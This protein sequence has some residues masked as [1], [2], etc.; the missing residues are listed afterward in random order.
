MIKN[1]ECIVPGLFSRIF[2]AR[3]VTLGSMRSV[4]IGGMEGGT[5]MRMKNE[6]PAGYIDSRESERS[7]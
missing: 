7:C 1:Q 4:V 3:A 6:R 2:F 5:A